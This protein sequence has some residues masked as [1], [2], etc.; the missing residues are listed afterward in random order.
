MLRALLTYILPLGA[1]DLIVPD[2]TRYAEIPR[3]MITS[4]DWVVPRLDGLLYFEK[5]PLFYWVGV[6]FS[7]LFI[8]IDIHTTWGWV[9]GVCFWILLGSLIYLYIGRR[10][11]TQDH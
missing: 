4:G 6:F 2:E 10:K 5:P 1:H 7:L 3:E 11:S 8:A 9:V